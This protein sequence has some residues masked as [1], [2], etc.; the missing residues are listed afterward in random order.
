[1]EGGPP[2]QFSGAP[3][4]SKTFVVK[5]KHDD[6]ND[7]TA[8]AL[9]STTL[10]RP[11]LRRRPTQGPIRRPADYSSLA[12]GL[13]AGICQAG[14][15]NPYDRALY[16]SVKENRSFLTF[17]NWNSPYTGFL[18]SL[19]GRAL[20]GGL[21]FPIEHFCLRFLNSN[22]S[23]PRSNFL[24][25]TAAG[26]CNAILLN[27]LTTIKYKTWSRPVNKGM[28]R[29]AID[30]LRK[31]QGSPRPFFNGLVPTLYRDIVF[32]GCYTWLRLQ[33]QWWFT[34]ET[35]E[36]WKANV[37]AAGLATI[38]SGPFNYARN[39]QY[40]TS[41]GEKQPSVYRV[42]YDLEQA[43]MREQGIVQ[44]LTLIQNRLRIGWGTARV[45]LG[46][47]FAHSIYDALQEQ[48]RQRQYGF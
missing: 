11:S 21:Y 44:K 41:S 36:Q 10:Y 42:L 15:F 37:L 8:K 23:N 12:S 29:E 40:A 39:I 31:S 48:L 34:L 20:S 17:A 33:M 43:V 28:I 4:T 45:A 19:G 35:R 25:G 1:M 6:D 2:K 9:A 32:G 38:V 16:L 14:V 3:S 46:M 13:I 18:Q 5:N 7:E 22:E 27:P 30:M 24:A 47:A 26:A